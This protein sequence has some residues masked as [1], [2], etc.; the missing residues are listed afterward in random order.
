MF[1]PVLRSGLEEGKGWPS[2]TPAED[3]E[4]FV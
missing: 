1:P 3:G 4:A 2:L